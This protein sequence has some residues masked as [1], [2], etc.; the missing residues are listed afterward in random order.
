MKRV[1]IICE[2]PT[3]QEFCKIALQR[4]FQ[5][6]NIFIHAPLI[7]KSGGGIVAWNDLKKQI[8]LHLN[9]KSAIVTTLIDYYGIYPKHA[10]PGWEESLQFTDK[11]KR[12]DFLELKMLEVFADN[13][14]HRVLPYLQLHEFEGLLF[15]NMDTFKQNFT[16]EELINSKELNQIISDH[17][18]PESI[19]DKPDTAPSKRL[20]RLIKGYNK[21]VYGSILAEEITIERIREKCVRFNDWLSKIENS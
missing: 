15:N 19:N 18:N 12:L 6:C 1:I 16:S 4:Y 14:Q 7:K 20:L 9:D 3:E 2:G 21:V 13:K 8:D 11:F 17:P 10:F 5:Q